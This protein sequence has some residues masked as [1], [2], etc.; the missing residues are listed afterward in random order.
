MDSLSGVAMKRGQITV[1]R[2]VE[3][4]GGEFL[5]PVY[6]ALLVGGTLW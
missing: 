1:L 3:L 2:R 5:L 4:A 6:S